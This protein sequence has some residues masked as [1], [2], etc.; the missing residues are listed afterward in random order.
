MRE[1]KTLPVAPPPRPLTEGDAMFEELAEA[2]GEVPKRERPDHDWIRGGTWKLIDERATLRK[3]GNLT[4][5]EGRRLTR[6]IHKSLNDDRRERALRA[7]HA[8]MA[9]LRDGDWRKGYGTLRAWTKEC[10]P[11]SSRPCYDTLEDQ[12]RERVKLYARRA[13]PGD[14]IPSRAERTPLTDTPPTDEELRLAAKKSNNGRS[15]GASKAYCVFDIMTLL[16]HN[17]ERSDHWLSGPVNARNSRPI[18]I[19]LPPVQIAC[20]AL[21]EN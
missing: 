15:G 1:R 16:V 3:E 2:V 9:A 11:A 5:A 8:I 10:D 12:T 19:S 18:L 14:R 7:G 17:S 4:Q 6:R 20:A 21:L 13:P